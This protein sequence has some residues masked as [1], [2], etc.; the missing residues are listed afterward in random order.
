MVNRI[1]LCV[2]EATAPAAAALASGAGAAAAAKSTP[3]KSVGKGRFR[4]RSLSP[5]RA[6]IGDAGSGGCGE[7]GGSAPVMTAAADGAQCNWALAHAAC[8]VCRVVGRTFQVAI[9]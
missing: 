8:R 7:D 4:S 2:E 5:T 9:R 6:A 1:K 3:G